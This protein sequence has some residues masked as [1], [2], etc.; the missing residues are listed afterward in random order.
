MFVGNLLRD[1]SINEVNMAVVLE[2]ELHVFSV[3]SEVDE[4]FL[5]L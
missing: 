3:E 1:V 5:I 2:S 4:L